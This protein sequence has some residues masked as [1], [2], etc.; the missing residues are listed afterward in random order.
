MENDLV[1]EGVERMAGPRSHGGDGNCQEKQHRG[2]IMATTFVVVCCVAATEGKEV[3]AENAHVNTQ[4]HGNNQSAHKERD[5]VK[6]V[7]QHRGVVCLP[8]R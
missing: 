5:L 8:Q 3:N 7:W 2:R 6:K 4:Q 1:G